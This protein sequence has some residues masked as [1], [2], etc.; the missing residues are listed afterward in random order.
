VCTAVA[1]SLAFW[2][3]ERLTVLFL[4]WAALQIDFFWICAGT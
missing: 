1:T 4:F 2:G 3:P